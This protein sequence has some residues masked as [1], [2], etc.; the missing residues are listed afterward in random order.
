MYSNREEG[1][2]KNFYQKLGGANG[3]G[4]GYSVQVT[5]LLFSNTLSQSQSQVTLGQV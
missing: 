2:L 1:H 3:K 4:I 5:H